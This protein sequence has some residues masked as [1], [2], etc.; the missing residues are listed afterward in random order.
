MLK[1]ADTC[2]IPFLPIYTDNR[3]ECECE[4]TQ[5]N[6]EIQTLNKARI[7]P[8]SVRVASSYGSEF[9]ICFVG[10]TMLNV[11]TREGERQHVVR[12][13]LNICQLTVSCKSSSDYREIYIATVLTSCSHN[14]VAS[15]SSTAVRPLL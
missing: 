12:G 7:V 14:F 10:L 9:T 4:S 11:S 13:I 8:V 2:R 15:S 5:K 1:V 3:T 6:R